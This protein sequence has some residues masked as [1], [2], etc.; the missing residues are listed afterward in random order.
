MKS[1]LLSL[2]IAVAL[3]IGQDVS[4]VTQ[5]GNQLSNGNLFPCLNGGNCTWWA[6]KSAMDNWGIQWSQLPSTRN[7]MYWDDDAPAKGFTVSR[8]PVVKSIA[9]KNSSP[10][11]VAKNSKGVCTSYEDYGHVAWVESVNG[12]SV[13]VSQM[14]YGTN[15]VKTTTHPQ[16]YFDAYISPRP[17]VTS[18]QLF[19]PSSVNENTSN[20][21]VCTTS[22]Y[23]S[24]GTNK[25]VAPLSWTDD[26]SA[27]SVNNGVLSTT[28]VSSDTRVSIRAEYQESGISKG[29][30]TSLIV[31][32]IPA[33]VLPKISSV[34]PTTV[35]WNQKTTFT[36]KGTNL[37][38]GLAFWIAECAG[39]GT[40][41]YPLPGGT[42]TSRTF[43]CTPM[44]TKGV[45]D[46]VIKDKA[47]GTTLYNFKVTVK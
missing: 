35:T 24:N 4:A 13:T 21:G 5:C 39:S 17:Q 30:T 9:V 34:S 29:A 23:Y 28:S 37:T 25:T 6:A 33:V 26:S 16:T 31:K 8:T 47:N 27:I 45:K 38:D 7:A 12:T 32:D 1:N 22:A 40:T 43:S 11:C 41:L 15:G 18:L 36:V 2:G 42:S 19:C 10:Y 44:Y 20:A 3:F 46:G 14:Y